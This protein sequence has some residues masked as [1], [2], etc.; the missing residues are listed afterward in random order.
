MTP[1]FATLH[2]RPPLN[3]MLQE[4]NCIQ[5][6][7]PLLVVPELVEELQIPASHVGDFNGCLKLEAE[8]VRVD[9][10]FARVQDGP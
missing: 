9:S 5:G 1:P 4:V 10:T 7:W 3:E 6:R 2:F 8:K